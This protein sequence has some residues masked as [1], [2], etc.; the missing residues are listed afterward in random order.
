M[1]KRISVLI[2]ALITSVTCSWAGSAHAERGAVRVKMPDGTTMEYKES[3]ALLIGVS[4]Y[5]NGWESID[6]IPQEL[7][8]VR[9]ALVEHRFQVETVLDPDEAEMRSAIEAF[10]DDHGFQRGN[11]LLVYFAGHGYRLELEDGARGYLVPADASRPLAGRQ[12]FLRRAIDF[13]EIAAIMRKTISQHVLFV[14]DSC[15]SG[16]MLSTRGER[17]P[18]LLTALMSRPARQI[19]T[20]GGATEQVPGISVFAPT[21]VD[22]LRGL[23]DIGGDKVITLSELHSYL[24]IH[25]AKHGL[26]PRVGHLPG[27]S[28]GEY[29]FQTES[30]DRSGK[31]NPSIPDQIQI[32]ATAAFLARMQRDFD[33][34][35]R[36][37]SDRAKVKAWEEFLQEYQDDYPHSIVDDALRRH[38]LEQSNE[39]KA[40]IYSDESQPKP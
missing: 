32:L 9:D 20:A 30:G 23:A 19:L 21:L 13:N 26:T 22:G 16:V 24:V 6:S 38:A 28:E 1:L 33:T 37:Q 18:T 36:I 14:F 12:E 8:L 34:A 31:I 40:V 17:R 2:G 10:V 5:E 39:L 29:L 4:R 3:H 27:Y 35:G 11:R 7:S 15:Y 25:I